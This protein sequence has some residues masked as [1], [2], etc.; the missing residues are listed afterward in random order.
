MKLTEGVYENLINEQ[1]AADMTH[2]ET[3]GL[4][5]YQDEIDSAESPKM[6]AKY[7]ADSIQ[8]RLEEKGMSISEQMVYANKLLRS[9]ESNQNEKLKVGDKFLSSVV[10]AARH[11][12]VN[13]GAVLVR[14]LSGFRTSNLFVGG[15]SSIPLG[16]EI[17]RDIASADHI[18]LIVSFLKLSGIRMIMESL[19]KFCQQEDHT[20]KVITTTY[21]GI[22]E[23]KAVEQLSQLP[24]TEVRISYN[25]GI[26]RLHAKSYI[27]ERNSGMNTAY[28]GSSNLS[29][30][31][32]TDGLEWNIR[33]TAV[34]NPHIIKA[35]LATFEQYWESPNFEDFEIERFYKEMEEARRSI[36][37]KSETFQRFSI[38]PHQKQILDKLEVERKQNGIFRNL[39]VAATGTGK[40]V[41]S[42]FDYM[43][44]K[45]NNP[46][47]DKL[48]FVAHREEILKQS[49]NTYRS[50][51]RDYDFGDLWVGTSKAKSLDHL[52]ISVQ[53]FNSH[54]EEFLKLPKDN[55]DYIVIDEAHHMV[56]SSYRAVIESFSPKILVG[57]TATPERMD[58]QSLLPDFCNKIS[59]EIRLPQALN[60]GLLTPFQYLCIT[61][62]VDLTDADLW[63]GSKYVVTKLSDKLCNKERVGLI[64]EKLRQYVADETRCKALCFCTDKRHANFMADMFNEVGLKAKALTSDTNENDRKDLN[65]A[66]SDGVINYLFVVDIFNE[67][68]DIPEI[69]TTLFL[70]PTESLTVFL[71]QL[72]RGLR[73]AP[74][75]DYLT[76][77]DFV[78]QANSSYDYASRFRSLLMRTDK[79]VKQQIENGFT[80]LPNGCSIYMEEKAK[81]NILENIKGAI[82][83]IKRL[84]QELA[85]YDYVPTLS[86][87]LNNNG[88]DV[89]LIYRGNNNCWTSLKR[90]AGKCKYA[91]DAFTKLLSKNI[92]NLAHANTPEYVAF[93]KK[94]FAQRN[95]IKPNGV[96]EERYALML[97]YTFYGEPVGK[98]GF[99]S[100]YE[101]LLKLTE[102]DLF[103]EEIVEL[104]DYIMD[105][106]EFKTMPIHDDYLG[107][108]LHGCY[109]SE[110]VFILLGKQTQDKT[111]SGFASG[112]LSIDEINTELF[113]VT[114]NKSDKDFSVSTMYNDYFISER[115]FHW[116]SQ[117]KDSHNGRGA[118]FVEQKA[119]GKRFLLFVR[120]NKKDGFGNTSPFY[121]LGLIDYISSHG[122]CPMNIEWSMQSPALPRFVKA[123]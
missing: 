50:V 62:S 16:E 46:V 55:Y 14:P 20:L 18:Y 12:E 92:G 66:L 9:L 21:C 40:T 61:D 116:Q 84:V 31:A 30:S 45:R 97:Y 118:R 25:K 11:I 87:F 78:A 100:I 121:C 106:L 6:L 90:A 113:F 33:V 102:Y 72:G 48:L 89:R 44:F 96:V 110:E 3:D 80:F 43:A 35:A 2:A 109:T 41:I 27:F 24:N 10:S 85:Q 67:G 49:L 103:C 32:Q 38:L 101:A 112:V 29:R 81:K 114:L 36:N 123:V 23:A 22:T 73:L 1:L 64:I 86:E 104:C 51:L 68:V 60:E 111:M 83:N 98:S 74:G 105:N 88:Q 91:D 42:A 59:A 77:L 34:E 115:K 13:N 75:K 65:K 26:E 99:A 117:N 71:Q 47:H 120:E 69:D 70:R 15:Q 57:L 76:V 4:V 8:R 56:A 93:I 54:K 58:G 37:D 28:I 119:N 107:L 7:V 122:D 95:M 108:R 82:Y 52:F 39:I 63:Q 53:T 94:V 5:C 19:R 17:S 79:P